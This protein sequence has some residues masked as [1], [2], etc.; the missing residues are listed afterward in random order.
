MKKSL[1]LEILEKKTLIENLRE[2]IKS[3]SEQRDIV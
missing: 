1:Q 3:K 2:L